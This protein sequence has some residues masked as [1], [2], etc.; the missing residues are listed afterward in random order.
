MSNWNQIQQQ[1]R[2]PSN[3]VVFFD[4]MIGSTEVG[5]IKMELFADIVSKTA[6]N[7]RYFIICFL[8]LIDLNQFMFIL[9]IFFLSNKTS[10]TV[11]YW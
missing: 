11:L 7:F 8:N 4:I 6:E 3:P 1:L 10:Q 5:R 9:S 2:H